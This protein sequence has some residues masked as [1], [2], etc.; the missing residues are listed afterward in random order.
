LA[1]HK[2]WKASKDPEFRQKMA[3]ILD[4][5]DRSAAGQLEPGARVIC[6]DEFGPLNLQPR[7]G[8]EPV[9]W[10]V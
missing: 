10:S 3:R 2:T 8:R 1:G 9:R 7:P 5:Y 6:V 4:L